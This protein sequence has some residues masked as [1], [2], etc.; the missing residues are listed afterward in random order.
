MNME[1]FNRLLLESIGTGLAVVDADT[2]EVMLSN[3]LFKTWFPAP[4]EGGRKISDLIE[5]VDGELV[6]LIEPD[7]YPE[8]TGSSGIRQCLGA[9]ET[10]INKRFAET[11][12]ED[13]VRADA[14]DSI[15]GYGI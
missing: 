5:A 12:M 14:A 6:R 1:A 13:L 3:P 9:A 4:E 10:A 15:M 8:F 7:G 11:T 2:H